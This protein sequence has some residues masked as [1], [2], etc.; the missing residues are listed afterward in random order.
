MKFHH[1]LFIS[2]LL[3]C[4]CSCRNTEK[5]DKN[6]S[7]FRYNEA[8]NITSLDPAFARD[9]ANIWAAR[10]LYNGLLQLDDHLNIL[11]CIAQRWEISS[12][13]RVYTF[14]LRR[15]VYFHDDPVFPGAKGRR[16]T[17]G[18]FVYSFS[19]VT[20][21][22]V[23]SPGSWI[24][25]YVEKK[26][27]RSSFLAPDDS[28]FVIRL[29]A[30][31]PPF[32]GLLTTIY[33]SVLPFEAINSYGTEFRSH[34][35]GT[36]PFK[37]RM[38]KE[39]VK[40]VMVKN[41]A[42][43]E[44]ENHQRLPYLDA[45][46]VTFFSDKQTAFL[47]FLKKNLDFISGID[48][49]YKDELLT[50][51]GKLRGKF[52]GRFKLITQPYLNTEY[53][54]FLVDSRDAVPEN[55]RKAFNYAI[56][57]KK[58]I[59]YLRNNIGTPGIYGMIPIGMPGFDSTHIYYDY[60][61]VKARKLIMESQNPAP[62]ITLSTTA[63]YLDLCK[64]IQ[65]QV[66]EVGIDMKIEISPP[67]ALKEMKAQ[68]KLPFFRGSWIADYPDAENYL[69]LFYSRNFCPQGPDYTHYSNPEYDKLFEK[70][71]ASVDDSE[72]ISDYRKMERLMMEDAP[73]VILYYDKVLRFVA[74]DVEG[75][76]IDPMNLLTLKRVKKIKSK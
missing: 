32:T 24:F 48:P 12:D 18:D 28:T 45:V 63:D 5:Q 36:G 30:S 60:D 62:V 67:A 49:G 10:Q 4:I 37:F 54:G 38:W 25:N 69:S 47:E 74:N 3:A 57:R 29:S 20:D 53:F 43:F 65:H 55:I 75:L 61:P 68:A 64:F 66:G 72:R 9:Q 17:A 50:S 6:L 58:M 7:V 39:G 46:S 56:D 22:S 14:H 51:D 19:R 71:M 33:C 23:A 11:P 13:G 34:P 2:F 8:A 41:P 1:W 26:N 59:R 16:V 40:L 31:F 44:F 52:E 21:P 42:Y 27:G 73:V 76:G 15:D 35:V 70:A